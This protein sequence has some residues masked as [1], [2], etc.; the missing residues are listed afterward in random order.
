MTE[1]TAKLH[2][3]LSEGTLSAEGSEE[4]VQSIYSDFRNRLIEEAVDRQPKQIP[5]FEQNNPALPTQD[6]Q[7]S[8]Q[9]TQTPRKS[10]SP[11]SKR[12]SAGTYVPQFNP[13]LDL[14]KLSEFYARFDLKKHSEKIL[15]FAIFMR[16]YLHKS[17]CS[18]DDIYSCYFTLRTQTEIPEAFKQAFIDTFNRTGWVQFI[19]KDEIRI[20]TAGENRFTEMTKAK[21]PE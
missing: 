16:D 17:P 20:T 15:V 9:K 7:S 1:T 3:N 8:P 18:A 6:G 13:D 10:K 14:S 5:A 19:S 12:Q 21:A 11:S 4:F 2:I